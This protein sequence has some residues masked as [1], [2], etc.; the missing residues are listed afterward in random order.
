MR[1]AFT[2]I[3]LLVVIAII[4]VLIALLVPAVQKVR[5]AS[6]RTQCANNLKQ[7]ALAVL[8]YETSVGSVPPSSSGGSTYSDR[9]SWCVQIL[10]YIEQDALYRKFN[11]KADYAKQD[12][13]ATGT[14]LAVFICPTRRR[15]D[16]LSKETPPGALTD[17]AGCGGSFMEYPLS[18]PVNGG[19][20][21]IPLNDKSRL[22]LREVLDGTS[23]TFLIGEKHVP[24]PED[25]FGTTLSYGDGSLY[26]GNW[27]R[28]TIRVVGGPDKLAQHPADVTGDP[29]RKFGS[30]HTGICQFAFIDGHVTP[31]TVATDTANLRRLARVDD[32][33]VVSIEH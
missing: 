28:Y 20:I 14:T 12:P 30:Y 18:N 11:L 23:N 3:E 31:M 32:G 26:H 7:L 5:E 33:E 6:N 27:P 19:A 22:R 8:D 9:P 15:A 13:A 25:Q 29:G 10:P 2:L 24:L 21:L 17:Y 4:G 1:K 16:L